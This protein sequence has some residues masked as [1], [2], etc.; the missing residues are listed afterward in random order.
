MDTQ[1][2]LE[3]EERPS[4]FHSSAGRDSE[5]PPD[6]AIDGAHI[7]PKASGEKGRAVGGHPWD[8]VYAEFIVSGLLAGG[9]GL[10]KSTESTEQPTKPPSPQLRLLFTS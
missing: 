6:A 8:R 1:L 3:I 2:F 10:G 9:I 5:E 4:P 7:D